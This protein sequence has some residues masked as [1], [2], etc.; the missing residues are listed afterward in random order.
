MMKD[1]DF[2]DECKRANVSLE[3]N[4]ENTVVKKIIPERMKQYRAALEALGL[5]KN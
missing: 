3:Y 2:L 4:D 1:P 5:L